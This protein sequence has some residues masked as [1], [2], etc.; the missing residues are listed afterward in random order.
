MN[1]QEVMAL[2]L[3]IEEQAQNLDD[4]TALE[5]VNLFPIWVAGKAY[6]AELRLRGPDGKLYRVLA[7]HVSQANWIPGEAV[8]LY[9]EVLPGQDGE[10]GEW[11]QPDS[12]NPYMTGDKVTHNGKTWVSD[13]DY[14]VYEPGVYGWTE[15]QG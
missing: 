8:S 1:R 9:A 7:D 14:N 10:I 13:I 5:R 15:I 3:L 4:E 6:K 12:T 2:R 11:V